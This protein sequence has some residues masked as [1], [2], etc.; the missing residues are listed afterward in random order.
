MRG[1]GWN[2]IWSA[3]VGTQYQALPWLAV[4]LGYNFTENPLEDR[5]SF[6]NIASPVVV[7]H[8]ATGGLGISV[9]EMVEANLAYYRAF[10]NDI[11]GPFVAPGLGEVPGSEVRNDLYEDSILLQISFKL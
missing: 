8:H 10:E 2:N 5:Q 6:F 7:Q 1:L 9:S 11:E 4:R 3:G